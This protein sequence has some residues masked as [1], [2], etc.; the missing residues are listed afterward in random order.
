MIIALAGRRVDAKG[1]APARF[2]LQ[3]VDQVR[4]R[5][6]QALLDAKATGLVASA[7]CGADLLALDE[8]GKLG[9]RRR[10][11]LPF[12]RDEFRAGSVIDRPGDWGPLYDRIVDEVQARG[13]LVLLEPANDP[14]EGYW[15]AT[16]A[17]LDEAQQ[18]AQDSGE[19]RDQVT[20]FAVYDLV[21]RG[22]DDLTVKFADEAKRRGLRVVNIATL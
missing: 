4:E 19:G 22:E 21:P 10:I 7:A 13:D 11:V 5:I 3:N 8:A 9:L 1:A 20:A 15:I 6:R 14:D 17:I 12:P 16:K 18:L 2:P